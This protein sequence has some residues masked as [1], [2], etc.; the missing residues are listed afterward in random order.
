M[1]E[2]KGLCSLLSEHNFLMIIYL[3]K[4]G[5]NDMLLNASAVLVFA[6][7][8]SSVYSSGQCVLDLFLLLMKLENGFV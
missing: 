5:C 3:F 8:F 2:V 1:R 7:C 4:E 6:A